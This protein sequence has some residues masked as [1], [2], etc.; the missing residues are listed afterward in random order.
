MRLIKSFFVI[1]LL[2]LA[3]AA[4]A[5][6]IGN[7]DFQT[8]DVGN[9]SDQRIMA[10]YESAQA[11]GLSI[12]QMVQLAVQ[13]GLPQSQAAELRRRLQDAQSGELGGQQA[14]DQTTG[15]QRSGLDLQTANNVFDTVFG[16]ATGIDS[17]RLYR[18]IEQIK[19]QSRQDSTNLANQKLR[20]RIY[21]YELFKVRRFQMD[22]GQ[23]GGM[24]GQGQGQGGQRVP[25]RT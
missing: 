20:D 3:S 2:C 18:T 11:R 10:I 13:R 21:G 5:Q 15:R 16:G 6:N 14:G 19:Y 22:Q 4:T 7:I 23:T 12:D 17:L 9:L 24:Q 8:A 25:G 1:A